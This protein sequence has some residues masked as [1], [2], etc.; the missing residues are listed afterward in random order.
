MDQPAERFVEFV[1][2]VRTHLTGDEKGEAHLFCE[3]LFQAFGHKGL[4]EVGGTLEYRIH[5][6]STTKFADLLWRPRLLLEMKK[7]YFWTKGNNFPCSAF[8]S[9]YG[10]RRS[11][12]F[13]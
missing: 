6:G 2:Y 13:I 7:C 11:A 1:H 8:R 3:R 9:S 5:K 12:L 10:I 4:K